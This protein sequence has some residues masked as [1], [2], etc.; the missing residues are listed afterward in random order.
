MV[1][2]THEKYQFLTEDGVALKLTRLRGGTKGPLIAAHG[3]GV[4]SGTFTITTTP[5]NLANYLARNGYDVWL[6]DWRASI[7]LPMTQFTLDDAARYDYSA[8][9]AEVLRLTGAD[10]VQILAHCMGAGTVMQAL[11][12]GILPLVRS[13]VLTSLGLHYEAPFSTD[14]LVGA[15]VAELCERAGLDYLSA[16][17][18]PE[19]PIL[20]AVWSKFVDLY[21]LEC[22][23]TVCHRLSFMYGTPY[24]HAQLNKATHDALADQFAWLNMRTFR[25]IS[26]NVR[27]GTAS[28]FDFG[29]EEN[30]R[31]YGV[32]EAPTYL[33]P[34]HLGDKPIDFV[35]GAHNVLWEP[36]SIRKTHAWLREHHP[37]GPHTCTVLDDFAHQDLFWGVDAPA[38]S[39]PVLLAALEAVPG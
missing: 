10:S 11:A 28:F 29:E 26:Q 8:A 32:E 17:E 7:D 3:A 1:T 14:W 12:L 23:S 15:H 39:W 22:D 37:H 21:H 9:V 38:K 2:I 30:R 5:D 13:A 20:H 4:W 16:R 31:R 34:D 19:H 27:R 6:L 25:H 33:I 35:T 18:H 36:K 24:R